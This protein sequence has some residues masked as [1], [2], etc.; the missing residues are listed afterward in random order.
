MTAHVRNKARLALT[1]R[2]A[3]MVGFDKKEVLIA[4][5][6]EAPLP[7]GSWISCHV[8]VHR[9]FRAS[10]GD[11]KVSLLKVVKCSGEFGDIV[12]VNFPNLVCI[13]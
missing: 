1:G 11:S 6:M 13:T 4:K 5:N 3:S 8:F 2:F 12:S 9:Y 7:V 10:V